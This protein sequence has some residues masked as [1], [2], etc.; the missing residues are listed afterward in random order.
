MPCH[1][2]TPR[3]PIFEWL[4]TNAPKTTYPLAY[5]NIT[6]VS[7]EEFLR[8]TGF[9]LPSD[10]DLGVDHPHG[11]HDLVTA[12]TQM[13]HCAPENIVTSAG[14]SEANYLVFSALLSPGMRSSWSS[15]GTGHCGSRR[16][17]S[18]LA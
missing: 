16:R 8:M 4:L 12:L 1:V 3:I 7:Y 18:A 2:R 14:G 13:Y 9:T 15:R 17:R 5:S 10:F 6:G 11:A